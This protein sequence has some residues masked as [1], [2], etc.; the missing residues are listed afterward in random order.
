MAQ[1]AVAAA[2][3]AGGQA[4]EQSLPGLHDLH[5]PAGD[6]SKLRGADGGARP[7]SAASSQPHLLGRHAWRVLSTSE[8]YS[9]RLPVAGTLAARTAAALPRARTSNGPARAKKTSSSS[10]AAFEAK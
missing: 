5:G 1:R 2:A 8:L 6:N 10:K 4:C 3:A 9:G 7:G